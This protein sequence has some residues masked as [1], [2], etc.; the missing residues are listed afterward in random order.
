MYILPEL[1]AEMPYRQSA[2]MG[3]LFDRIVRLARIILHSAV[4]AGDKLQAA[5]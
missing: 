2:L 4:T 3:K 1:F 5:A